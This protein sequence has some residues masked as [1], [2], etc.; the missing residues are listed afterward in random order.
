MTVTKEEA[1]KHLAE[2]E[3][4]V[5]EQKERFKQEVVKWA[6][7]IEGLKKKLTDTSAKLKE[8]N[9]D[10]KQANHDLAFAHDL[11]VKQIARLEEEAKRLKDMEKFGAAYRSLK[12]IVAPVVE[13]VLKSHKLPIVGSSPTPASAV[14]KHTQA[15]VRVELD[16][17]EVPFNTKT[18]RG[19]ILYLAS[20]G[21]FKDWKRSADVG[22]ELERRG[23]GMHDKVVMM[24]LA[25]VTKLGYLGR[26]KRENQFVYKVPDEGVVFKGA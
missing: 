8:E 3:K 12:D 26:T 18:N 9:D 24:E 5:D 2:L 22:D 7:Q 1:L 25:N 4:K 21:F 15:V 16:E 6:E 20:K 19:K 23:W 14:I 11:M 13:D 17:K 10:F